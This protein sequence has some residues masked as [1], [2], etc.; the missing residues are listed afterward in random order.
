MCS[1]YV[2][3]CGCRYSDF[4]TMRNLHPHTHRKVLKFEKLAHTLISTHSSA[5]CAFS[6][7][8]CQ[9]ALENFTMLAPLLP[10][11]TLG[12]LDIVYLIVATCESYDSLCKY[13]LVFGRRLASPSAH[14]RESKEKRPKPHVPNN[15]YPAT[16]A[17]RASRP[18]EC[19]KSRWR[20]HTAPKR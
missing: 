10:G 19:R 13:V 15:T 18:G 17:Q 5:C 2:S 9:C 20:W 16:R 7:S 12:V 3:E 14:N 1:E 4:P 11:L 6:A 8:E